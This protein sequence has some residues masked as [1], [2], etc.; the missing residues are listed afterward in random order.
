MKNILTVISALLIFTGGVV[1]QVKG[2]P[3]SIRYP[4]YVLSYFAQPGEAD[5]AGLPLLEAKAEKG[6]KEKIGFFLKGIPG[7][8]AI[9]ELLDA[10]STVIKAITVNDLTGKGNKSGVK[11]VSSAAASGNRA[12]TNYEITAPQG[13]IRLSVNAIASAVTTGGQIPARMVISF[14]IQSAD[15]PSIAM[16]VS[17]P[18]EGIAEMKGSGFLISGKTLNASLAGT[19]NPVPVQSTLQK[20]ILSFT[21][22]IAT[23]GSRDKMVPVFWLIIDGSRASSLANAKKESADILA[24]AAKQISG[25]PDLI[26]VS[27][28]DKVNTLPGDTAT[29]SVVCTNIGTGA[30]SQIV[31]QN[32]VPAGTLYIEGSAAGEGCEI[33]Y[34]RLQA[35][36]PQMGAVS[37]IKWKLLLDLKPGEE[38]MVQFKVKIL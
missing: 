19:I 21:T 31:L 25:N 14:S 15:Y 5:P 17:L 6:V 36:A 28:L 18:V 26:I 13:K 2:N 1:G 12:E 16:R 37:L 33:I 9:L 38:K 11:I 29:Y 30:A 3:V 7:Q 23:I 8:T 35:T 4:Q 27:A 32:P 34:D 24:A 20:N 10:N 22:P